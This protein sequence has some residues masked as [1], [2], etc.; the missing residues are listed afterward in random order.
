V[1]HLL[2]PRSFLAR[3]SSVRA[4]DDRVVMLGHGRPRRHHTF[5]STI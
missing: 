1:T 5:R 4:A 2:T 3:T